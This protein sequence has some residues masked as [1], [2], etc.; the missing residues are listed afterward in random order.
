MEPSLTL[1]T[2]APITPA[3]AGTATSVGWRSMLF[4]VIPV[5]LA[6]LILLGCFILIIFI[7]WSCSKGSDNQNTSNYM[8]NPTT[9]QVQAIYF[10]V[11]TIGPQFPPARSVTY[12]RVRTMIGNNSSFDNEMFYHFNELRAKKN[13]TVPNMYKALGLY[14]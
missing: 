12:N 13:L 1:P 7:V 3:T 14:T 2:P 5:W 11:N 4:G 8:A 10:L 6:A 9:D